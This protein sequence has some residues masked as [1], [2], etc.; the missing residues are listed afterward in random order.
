[1]PGEA[2]SVWPFWA[3]PEIVGGDVFDGGDAAL[4]APAPATRPRATTS[5]SVPQTPSEMPARRDRLLADW[6]M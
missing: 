1:V 3:S 6:D 4:E 5:V 2:W